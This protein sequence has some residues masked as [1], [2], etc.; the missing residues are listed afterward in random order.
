M[1]SHRAALEFK[2]KKLCICVQCNRLDFKALTTSAELVTA[3]Y[4]DLLPEGL[5]LFFL[6]FHQQ[7]DFL[8]FLEMMKAGHLGESV[9]EHLPLAQVVILGTQDP[10]P[11]RVPCGEP[12]SPSACVPASLCFLSRINE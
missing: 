12:A 6:H 8:R 2:F 3:Y 11:R 4:L 5:S 9:V 7:R 10:V 1:L